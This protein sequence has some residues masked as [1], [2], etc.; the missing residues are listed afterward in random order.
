MAKNCPKCGEVEEQWS[1]HTE[2]C[3]TYVEVNS[4]PEAWYHLHGKGISGLRHSHPLRD[5]ESVDDP[6]H[7]HEG[8]PEDP[9]VDQRGIGRAIYWDHAR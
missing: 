5:G 3:P 2:I 4:Y 7:D 1:E 6:D 8:G 9:E